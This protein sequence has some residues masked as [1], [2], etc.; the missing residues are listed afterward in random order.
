[1]P[2]GP[3]E[4]RADPSPGDLSNP[5]VVSASI[6]RVLP[7]L[8]RSIAAERRIEPPPEVTAQMDRTFELSDQSVRDLE[9]TRRRALA[10]DM[11]G[12]FRVMARF[13]DGRDRARAA[14]RAA[15]LRC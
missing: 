8:R 6:D 14:A 4:A 9:E 1:M 2:R 12:A 13:L 7:L 10:A 15:G 11:Q 3:P 5:E